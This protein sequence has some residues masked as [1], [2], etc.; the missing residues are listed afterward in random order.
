MVAKRF[1]DLVCWQL[2]RELERE[3]YAFTA[4]P[5]AAKDLEYCRQIRKSSSSAPRNMAEGF[6]RY[7]PGEFARFMRNALGSLNET[8]D[9]LGAGYEQGYLSE[10]RYRELKDLTNRAIGASVRLA[11]YLERAKKGWR[12]RSRRRTRNPEL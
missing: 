1:E 3:V 10:A 12:G 11:D 6:G 2:A 5:P 7:L 8:R 9:H 4:M